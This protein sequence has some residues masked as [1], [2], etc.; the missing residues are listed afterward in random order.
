[1][2]PLE[3]LSKEINKIKNNEASFLGMDGGNIYSKLW[4]CGVEFG[5]NLVAMEEYYTPQNVDYYQA[6]R[7]DVPYRV[8]GSDCFLKSTFDRSLA[9]MYLTL[10]GNN[11]NPSQEEFVDTLKNKMYHNDSNTFKFNLF[12]FAKPDTS[13]DQNIEKEFGIS[14]DDYYGSIFDNRIKFIRNLTERF[15]PE[16]ILCFS[17]KG[18]SDYFID[19]FVPDNKWVE[20]QKDSIE[21]G[22]GK[23]ARISV[24]KTEDY[25]VIIIPFL[26]RGNLS[27]HDDVKKMARHLKKYIQ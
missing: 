27:S 17:P 21:K 15:S 12:P 24:F 23:K 19:T 8:A 20:Y 14:K 7:F 4:F 26:G 5:A 11:E 9:I 22:D 16:T 13:W 3:Y 6:K 10:T 18:Y 2:K 1:M 25:Q